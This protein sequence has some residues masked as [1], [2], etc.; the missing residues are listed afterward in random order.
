MDKKKQMNFNLNNFLLAVKDIL[1][2]RDI[3]QN[4]VSVS[5]SLRVAYVSL[6]IGEKLEKE[7]KEMFDLCAYSLF[8]HYMKEEHK[9]LFGF[10]ESIDEL[11]KISDFTHSLDQKFD[12]SKKQIQNRRDIVEFV[13][14][15]EDSILKNIFLEMSTTVDFW[16]DLQNENMM[17]QYIYS[18]LYDFTQVLTFEEVLKITSLFGSIENDIDGLLRNCDKM[19]QFYGFEQKDRWTFLIAASM[20]NFGKLSVPNEI[21]CKKEKLIDD[22]YKLLQSY[23]YHNKN[24]LNSIYGF[25]DITK[26][27][28]RHQERLDGSGYP[29]KIEAKDLSLKE[30]LMAVL[31]TYDALTSRKVYRDALTKEEAVEILLLM[32]KDYYLD[33]TI[34]EDFTANIL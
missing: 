34:I 12:F 6:K 3:E 1:D 15:S 31:N 33:K 21:L 30:R 23:I 20:V 18:T 26:W 29:S 5:H 9:Q 13:T 17:M 25:Q 16:L 27:A 22:E 19:T 11:A 8:Y 24:A 7:P 32:E 10:N 2:V 28:T 4:N 14:K